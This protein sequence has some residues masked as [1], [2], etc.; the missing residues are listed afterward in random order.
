MMKEQEDFLEGFGH[1]FG[2]KSPDGLST[3]GHT[4]FLKPSLALISLTYSISA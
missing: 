4:S 1:Y 3:F 2:V